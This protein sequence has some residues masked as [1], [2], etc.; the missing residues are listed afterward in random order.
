[1]T[2]YNRFTTGIRVINGRYHLTI[3]YENTTTGQVHNEQSARSFNSE[4]EATKAAEVL[5]DQLMAKI[6]GIT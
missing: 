6:E 5:A 4:H 2:T 1:M 3:K